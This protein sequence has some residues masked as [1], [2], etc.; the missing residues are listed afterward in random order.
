MGSLMRIPV[1]QP[2]KTQGES[3]VPQEAKDIQFTELKDM[4]RQLN[5]T[6]AVLTGSIQEKDAA[7]VRLTEEVSYLR[8]KFFGTSSE[9]RPDIRGVRYKNIHTAGVG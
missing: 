4:I 1:H 3:K 7:I 2:T 8:R 6:I 9:K 5:T